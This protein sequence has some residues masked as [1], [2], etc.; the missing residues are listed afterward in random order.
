M[1]KILLSICCLC[2]LSCE[3]PSTQTLNSGD[4]IRIKN[5]EIVATVVDGGTYVRFYYEDDFGNLHFDV[6][7]NAHIE[8]VIDNP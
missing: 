6:L 5:T 7:H 8:K 1:K 2:L 3:A 4:K